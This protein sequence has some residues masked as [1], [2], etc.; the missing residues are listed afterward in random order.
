MRK[1]AAMGWLGYIALVGGLLAVTSGVQHT[2]SGFLGCRFSKTVCQENEECIDDRLFGSCQKFSSKKD[3]YQYYLDTD[4]LHALEKEISRLISR[5]YTW[6]NLYTQCVL[7]N[8]LLAFRKGMNHDE[9]WCDRGGMSQDAFENAL[10]EDALRY[11]EKN[12]QEYYDQ[13]MRGEGEY[14]DVASDEDDL[15]A[16]KKDEFLTVHKYFADQKRDSSEDY[17]LL[18]EREGLGQVDLDG[19]LNQLGADDLDTLQQYLRALDEEE[20]EEEEEA[21]LAQPQNSYLPTAGDDSLGYMWQNDQ[22]GRP[23]FGLSEEGFDLSQPNIPV[24]S[25]EILS[26]NE[27]S[28][29]DSSIGNGLLYSNIYKVP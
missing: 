14:P 12:F 6:D 24:A 1:G 27:P 20:Q 23:L 11:L 16:E 8:I 18:D 9:T 13:L 4:T 7:G 28:E 19:L 29:A 10:T 3:G 17:L 2:Y 5:G 26:P 21:V 15:S 22:N 25:S